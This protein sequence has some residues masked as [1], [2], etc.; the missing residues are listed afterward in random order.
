MEITIKINQRGLGACNENGTLEGGPIRSAGLQHGL[1]C[2]Y[3]WMYHC[4]DK[5][6]RERFSVWAKETEQLVRRAL[7]LLF[8][9]P[10]HLATLVASVF[11]RREIASPVWAL[12]VQSRAAQ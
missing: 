1:P 4:W 5:E 10:L 11:V 2:W 8:S 6:G 3:V 7:A 9:I 12:L